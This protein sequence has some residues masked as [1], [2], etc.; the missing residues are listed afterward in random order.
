MDACIRLAFAS[1]AIAGVAAA[2]T[3]IKGRVMVLVDTSGSMV[4]HFDNNN[5]CGGDG[6]FNSRYSDGFQANKNFY[7]GTI[8]SGQP[9]GV[10]SRLY[11]AKAALTNVVN[12]TGDLDFGL[13]R[14]VP[15]GNCPNNVN[16]C[17]FSNKRNTVECQTNS[18]YI[19]N[20]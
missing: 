19:D 18:D 5:T 16:C 6:D 3:Q 17:P 1:L 13:M 4:W 14:F 11:A 8:N 20:G 10:N 2:Q 7:P 12:A 9:D 15:N